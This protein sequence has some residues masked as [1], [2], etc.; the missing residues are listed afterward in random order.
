MPTLE[1]AATQVHYRTH[2]TGPG[3]LL[4]HGSTADSEANFAGLRPYFTEHRTVITPDYAGSGLTALPAGGVLTLDHLVAQIAAVAEQEGAGTPLDVVGV[5]LGAVV[6]AALAADH[7]HLVNRLVLAGGWARNNDPRQQLA[8]GLWRRLADLDP[9][10]YGEFI[11]LLS[12][13]PDHLARLAPEE[14]AKI[15]AGAVP[16]EGARRQLDLDITVDIQNKL[17]EIRA[18]TL[19]IGARHDQVIPVS[20]SKDLHTGIAGSRYAEIDGG[21]NTPFENPAALAGLVNEFLD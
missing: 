19:V 7:P 21:H 1:V 10:A 11:T 17:A 12:L 3:L 14:I 20:H 2:G 6:A 13:A 15:A 18:P 9:Q 8:L 16:T 5:S 4:V